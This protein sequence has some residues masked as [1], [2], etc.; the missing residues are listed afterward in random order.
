M[1][2]CHFCLETDLHVVDVGN[3]VDVVVR[4]DGTGPETSLAEERD[5]SARASTSR[6]VPEPFC[7]GCFKEVAGILKRSILER[8]IL[9]RSILKRAPGNGGGT[10]MQSPSHGGGGEPPDMTWEIHE[11]QRQLDTLN[12]LLSVEAR[13]WEAYS[14]LHLHL[15]N[16]ADVR[17]TLQRKME[18][19][20]QHLAR[21]NAGN[22]LRR[23]EYFKIHIPTSASPSIG[24]INGFRL[25]TLPGAPVEWWE[26]N[27]AWG[28][29]VLLLEQLRMEVLMPVSSKH[30]RCFWIEDVG[31]VTWLVRGS[32]PR[33][34]VASATHELVGP[35]SKILC[36]GYDRALVLFVKCLDAVGKALKGRVG[37]PPHEISGSGDRIG[38][39]SV[40]YGLSRDVTWTSALRRVLENLDWCL[41]R[42]RMID[43]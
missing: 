33:V 25:G 22:G 34:V 27:T 43:L 38:G 41:T 36:L 26:L 39:A 16:V 24:T 18:C 2:R 21:M 35:V 1:I 8:S 13:Y 23:Y 10:Q 40:R 32:Y 20:E 31:A 6:S 3:V 42:S 19:I 14:S 5:E 15:L 28:I 30:G 11:K 29:A 12:E 37:E 17:D 9:E 7:E 4:S